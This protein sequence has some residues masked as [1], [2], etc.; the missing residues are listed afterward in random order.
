VISRFHR[1]ACVFTALSLAACATPRTETPEPFA[2]AQPPAAVAPSAEPVADP[3]PPAS[4]QA[5]AVAAKVRSP[6]PAEPE[7]APHVEDLI[8]H[9]REGF[10]LPPVDNAEVR[11]HTAWFAKNPAYTERVLERARPFMQHVAAEIEAR[12]LPA[13]LAFLPV[14]ESAFDPFAY[15]HGRAAGLWQIIPGTGRRFGLKQNWWYDG[16]RDVVESTRAALDYLEYLHNMFG[17]DWL[18]AIAAYNCGEGTVGRAVRRNREAGKPT[19]FWHLRLPAETRGYVPRLLG[20]TAV[21][22]DPDTHGLTL[23]QISGQPV[24]AAVE[25]AGQIDLAIAAELA[26]IELGELQALNPGLNRW[27]TDP[28]GPHR[29]QLPVATIEQF[30]AALA[31][32]PASERMVWHRHVVSPGDTLGGIARRYRTKVAVLQHVNDLPG[33]QIRVGTQLMVP[34]S[35]RSA[36]EYPLSAA[37]RLAGT[38]ERER[39]GRVRS[40]HTVRSGDSLWSIA[41]RHGVG[42]RELAAWNGMAPGDTLSVGRKL[43]VW[44]PAGAQAAAA[45]PGRAPGADPLVRRV[46]YTVRR[47]DSLYRI[48]SNFRVSVEDI[49][50]WNSLEGK[51]HLQP[52][53]RLVLHVDVTAQSGG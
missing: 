3:T 29:L 37:N 13:E 46:N 28:D 17:G 49:K 1:I 47:G 22:A 39:A 15:S 50:R 19:D 21:I 9:L 5:R 4:G 12:G 2:D 26:G 32:L 25:L 8:A 38:Q 16:R 43:V 52:G 7:A 41:R 31:E 51:R 34:T 20:L 30:N 44:K 14:V 18:L 6:T 35:T 11:Q 45:N 53:Q 27:A 48:A 23:P 10:S 33:T 36:E 42:M 40:E 24:F